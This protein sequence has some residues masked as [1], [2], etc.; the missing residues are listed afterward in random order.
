MQVGIDKSVLDLGRAHNSFMD[1]VHVVLIILACIVACI[2]VIMLS[3]ALIF[4]WYQVDVDDGDSGQYFWWFGR[5]T[6]GDID[7]ATV[8][9]YVKY[10][11]FDDADSIK[12]LYA[13]VFAFVLVACLCVSLSVCFFLCIIPPIQSFRVGETEIK[14]MDYTHHGFAIFRL[15]MEG[16][17]CCICIVAFLLIAIIWLVY[18]AHAAALDDTSFCEDDLGTNPASDK[19]CD[20]WAGEETEAGNDYLWGPYVGWA[21]A[22]ISLF[23]L[24]GMGLC[25]LVAIIIDLANYFS[26]SFGFRL[27]KDEFEMD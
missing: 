5:F 4:P 23:C 20:T 9:T 3:I 27:K 24:C 12:G 15:V 11:D 2:V 14:A 17:N 13:A 26:F 22:L 19:W 16:I 25:T 1:I 6:V 21:F 7:D 8:Y 18:F 10:D